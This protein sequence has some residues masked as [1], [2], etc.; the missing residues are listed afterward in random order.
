MTTRVLAT[1]LVVLAACAAEVPATAPAP[2]VEPAT[3]VA[4]ADIGTA[5]TNQCTNAANQCQATCDRF[6]RP[7]CEENCDNRFSNCMHAC[8]CPISNEFDQVSLDHTDPT[9]QFLCVGPINA[10]GLSYQ[11]Y[12]LFQRTD[13]IRETLQCDGLITQTVLSSTVS[14]AGPCFHKLFPNAP[15]FPTQS[16]GVGLCTF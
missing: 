4:T 5:C 6:P 1:C 16:S 8:G 10:N 3:S 13:H 12:N 15:C 2:A 11:K 14:S 7:N 9:N